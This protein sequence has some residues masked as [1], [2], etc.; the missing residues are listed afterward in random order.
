MPPFVSS[1]R[2]RIFLILSAIAGATFLAYARC[3]NNAFT[4]WDDNEYAFYLFQQL[5]K[6]HSSWANVAS[7][8]FLPADSGGIEPAYVK[9][10]FHPLAMISMAVDYRLSPASPGSI[11][12]ISPVVFHATAV[13]LHVAN[14]LLVF[15]FIYLCIVRVFPTAGAGTDTKRALT[16]A[17]I[18]SLLFGIH[19]L[20]VESVAWI[21]ERKDV[22]YALWFLLSLTLYIQYV[23]RRR[24]V[25][26]FCALAAFLLSLLSKGQAVSLA[27]AV[28]LID[29][30]AGR[31]LLSKK[32][33]IE[34]IPW[35]AMA[36]LFGVIAVNAQEQ[37][38]AIVHGGYDVWTRIVFAALS[39]T[40]YLF[41]TLAPA[42]GLSAL[43]PYPAAGGLPPVYYWSFVPAA[44]LCAAIVLSIKKTPM[45]FF[46]LAFFLINMVFLLQ[47]IPVGKAMMADRYTYL[48]SIGLFFII[49]IAVERIKKPFGRPAR[50]LLLVYA[51][52]LLGLTVSR[53]GVWKDSIT[54][55]SDCIAHSPDNAMAYHNRASARYEAK[56]FAG[57][58]SDETEVIRLDPSMAEAWYNRGNARFALGD[59]AGTVSDNTAC[60]ERNPKHSFAYY[61]RG[62]ARFLLGQQ[63]EAF[64]DFD[65]SVRIDRN[66]KLGYFG[67][68]LCHEKTGKWT[69]A[70]ADYGSALRLDPEWAEPY[71]LRAM[72]YVQINNRE[73][74]CADLRNAME[75][76]HAEAAAQFGRLCTEAPSGVR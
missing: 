69:D 26:Y 63:S 4:N 6:V 61:L 11:P 76:G 65:T 75:L 20:H 57:A 23:S 44:A 33:I 14:T 60:V 17:A 24:M 45:V 58:V 73:A 49:G 35:Y 38:H 52:M 10:N 22:L 19:P 21:S 50:A 18:T 25:W 59:L 29:F 36:L 64:S 66:F 16:I 67:R 32:V 43:Y 1:R 47:L 31:P 8:F 62:R 39:L 71:F 37:G 74:C 68:A 55:W 40:M 54:L 46:G 30:T 5:E 28:T 12:P 27:L 48:S 7:F 9:G 70:I 15:F 56:D 72:A 41:K 34:K 2:I 42:A 13:L 53:C 3:F 51:A